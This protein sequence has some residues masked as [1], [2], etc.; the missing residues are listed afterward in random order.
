[1][2]FHHSPLPLTGPIPMTADCGSP[3]DKRLGSLTLQDLEKMSEA[4]GDDG[5]VVNLLGESNR[6]EWTALAAWSKRIKEF[7]ARGGR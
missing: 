3:P 1:M 7:W 5:V 6:L 4:G 2:R